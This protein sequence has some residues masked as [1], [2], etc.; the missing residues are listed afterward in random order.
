MIGLLGIL[1]SAFLI[2]VVTQK[3]TFR[4][5][6]KYVHTFVLSI[7]L[8]KKRRT[9]AADIIK[10][11]LKIWLLKRRDQYKTLRYVQAQRE[12]FSRILAVQA[13]KQQQKL[14]RDNCVGFHE[15]MAAQRSTGDMLETVLPQVTDVQNEFNTMEQKLMNFDNRLVDLQQSMNIVLNHIKEQSLTL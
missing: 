14:L 13:T 7:E 15:L 9:Q 12:L 10:S 8:A 1:S 4:R 6:E 3:L 2:A 11:A 5:E